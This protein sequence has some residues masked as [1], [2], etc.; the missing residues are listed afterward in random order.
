MKNWEETESGAEERAIETIPRLWAV[1]L[2]S[3]F[4]VTGSPFASVLPAFPQTNAFF[5]SFVSGSPPCRTK[6]GV[7]V[8]ERAVVETRS[9]EIDE[10]L[11]V[12]RGA[13]E[14][15]ADRHVT[16]LGVDDGH[17]MGVVVRHRSDQIG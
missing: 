1:S 13:V 14:E 6:K 5:G 9:R 17:R 7:A 15:E 2:N 10:V 4:N 12:I 3:G 16:A 11:H 8:K